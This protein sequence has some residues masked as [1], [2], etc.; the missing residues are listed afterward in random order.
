MV[1]ASMIMAYANPQWGNK[2]EKI[3]AKSTD[4]YIALDISQSMMAEDVSPNRL[5]RAKRLT[6]NVIQ[7]LKG[8]RIGLILFAGNAYLQM[9]LSS[10][11]S[12]AQLFVSSANTGQASTQGTA[13]SEAIDL[14][15]RAYEPGKGNQRALIIITDG[16]NHDDEAIAKARE[17]TGEGLHIFTVGI[18]TIEGSLV[19]YRVQGREQFKRDEN[20]NPVKSILN[21]ELIEEL[22]R[23][24]NGSSFLIG[25]GN[26]IVT[27]IKRDIDLLEK[28]EVEQ[29][30]FTDYTSYFQYF[31]IFGII[32]L[33]FE[34]IISDKKSNLSTS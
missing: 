14:A 13:I 20:G 19:P 22:A 15:L 18:G 12:A 34:F 2:K 23:A 9:P 8:N 26:Q 31:L 16:E 32:F 29:R 6:Q 3:K 4:V 1:L 25:Q 33:I 24:G 7:A 27:G 28:D 5:E 10:D 21:I 17:A 11:Y 30:A